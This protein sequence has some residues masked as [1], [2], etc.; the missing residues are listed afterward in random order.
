ML[1]KSPLLLTKPGPEPGNMLLKFDIFWLESI[2]RY[3]Y[4]VVCGEVYSSLCY[5]CQKL[6]IVKSSI[7]ILTTNNPI[8]ICD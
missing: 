8:T 1:G 4:F 6:K 2:S 3:T 7:I 5:F